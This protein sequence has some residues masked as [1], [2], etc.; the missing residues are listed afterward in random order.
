MGRKSK[1]TQFDSDFHL[2]SSWSQFAFGA[3][4]RPDFEPAHKM[5]CDRVPH[6]NVVK[7]GELKK[8]DETHTQKKDFLESHATVICGQVARIKVWDLILIPEID[9]TLG[10]K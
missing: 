6:K 8:R 1:F 3:F 2:F 4:R 10:Y 9:R 5:I 7:V